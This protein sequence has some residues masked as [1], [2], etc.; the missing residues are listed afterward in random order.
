MRTLAVLAA[1]VAAFGGLEAVAEAGSAAD[2]NGNF[3]VVDVEL[4]PPR[5]GTPS[6]RQG[7]TLG[8]HFFTGNRLTGQRPPA[9]EAETI[10][11]PGVR[12]NGRL[13]P[14]CPL[15]RTAQEIGRTRCSGFTRVGGGTGEVDVRPL[16]AGYIPIRISA[17]NGTLHNG[18]PSLIFLGTGIVGGQVMSAELDFVARAVGGGL[19]LVLLSPP[20][21]SQTG[22]F[23]LTRADLTLG[24]AIAVRRGGRF[25]RVSLYES[26]LSCPHQGWRLS[27][28]TIFSGGAGS[29]T[30]TDVEPCVGA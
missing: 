11:L 9:V 18:D 28:T 19:N 12:T 14:K 5:A 22:V 25:G 15:P 23:S 8:Y 13:F 27:Q 7:V 1:T 29:L 20:P 16:V 26:P 6:R 21:G 3:M 30:A 24:R 17:F 2:A 10:R 4:S